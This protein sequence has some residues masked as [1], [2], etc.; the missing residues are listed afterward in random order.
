L[1]TITDKTTVFVTTI[2]ITFDTTDTTDAP[3]FFTFAILGF[4]VAV[5]RRRK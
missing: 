1:D 3:I 2:P 4:V 5:L